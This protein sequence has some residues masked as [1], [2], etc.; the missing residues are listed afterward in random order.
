MRPIRE[1]IFYDEE[2][3]VVFNNNFDLDNEKLLEEEEEE[4]KEIVHQERSFNKK[5]TS[6]AQQPFNI[7]STNHP[8]SRNYL[9]WNMFGKVVTRNHGIEVEEELKIISILSILSVV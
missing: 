7:N 6:N 2:D 9:T 5:P 3:D 1:K 4:L 8:G